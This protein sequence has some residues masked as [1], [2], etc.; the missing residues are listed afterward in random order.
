MDRVVQNVPGTLQL[1]SPKPSTRT[2][3]SDSQSTAMRSSHSDKQTAEAYAMVPI[4]LMK[5]IL[6]Y[7]VD[8]EYG[9]RKE[10][11]LTKNLSSEACIRST[12][13]DVVRKTVGGVP[14][15]FLYAGRMFDQPC[16]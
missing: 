2:Y 15:V 11:I 3:Y 4:G 5:E 6:P 9:P 16:P 8:K 1:G 13:L 10:K 12:S 14:F 7:G